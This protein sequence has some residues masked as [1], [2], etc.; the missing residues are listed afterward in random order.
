MRDSHG[1]QCEPIFSITISTPLFVSSSPP[2]PT[3]LHT[4]THT[5]THAHKHFPLSCHT[6]IQWHPAS[7]VHPPP[8]DP[9]LSTYVN[10]CYAVHA[11][12]Y[13]PTHPTPTGS[14]SLSLSRMHIHEFCLGLSVLHRRWRSNRTGCP[15]ASKSIGHNVLNLGKQ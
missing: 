13:A 14:L 1:C 9:D 12:K 11:S 15:E 4:H 3:P 10:N 2:Y 8:Y 6:M 5:H 7:I